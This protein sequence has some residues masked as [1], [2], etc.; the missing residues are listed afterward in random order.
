MIAAVRALTQGVVAVLRAP[1]LLI[2][3]LVVT[4]LASVPFAWAM[5]E[6]LQTALANQPDINLD[7]EE[8][9]AEWWLEY[10][11]HARGLESTFTPAV[12]GFAAPLDNLSALVD[13]TPRPWVLA[14]PV[15]LY[16]LLWALLWTVALE[17]FWAGAPLR[18]AMQR[19][20]QRFPVMAAISVTAGVIVVA[21]YLTLH[22]AL[23]GAVYDSLAR[24]TNNER[25]A[26][27]YR[28]ALYLVF[29]ATLALV[30]LLADYA[31]IAAVATEATV[32]EA[33]QRGVAFLRNAPGAV[34]ALYVLNGALFVSLF[35]AYGLID[36]RA[37]GWRAV[38]VGQLYI[39]AR[40]AL[41]LVFV[42]SEVRLVQQR[43]GAHYGVS[44]TPE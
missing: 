7:A 14:A 8:I 25:T 41:R 36:R 3:A 22:P 43:G 33:F 21:L 40:L 34:V 11:K 37:G 32:R 9:D 2:L 18:H 26:F 20:I 10:R 16:M 6:R 19:S 42:A 4:L 30:S 27:A 1:W 38:V 39:V 24:T 28:V 35:V 44:R 23:F 31:R 13:A 5:H 12:L 17:R 15:L 29:G